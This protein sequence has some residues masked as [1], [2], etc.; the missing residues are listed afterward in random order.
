MAEAT[1]TEMNRFV[2][3]V[4]SFKNNLARLNSAETRNAVYASNNSALIRDYENTL[5][6]SN[7]LN[8]TIEGTVGAWE[9]A[10]SGWGIL[11]SQTSMW[12]GDAVDEIRSWFQTSN[13]LGCIGCPQLGSFGAVQ[14]PA[15]VWIAGIVAAAYALNKGMEK[16][17]IAIEATKMQE[18]NPNLSRERAVTLARNAIVG[19]WF[20]LA[21][22]VLLAAGAVGLYLV[23]RKR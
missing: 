8:S 13:N 16:I 12:I 6:Q 14:L 23:F 19:S 22:G 2:A 17:F 20:G 1:Q 5:T 11:T 4:E 15:A 10:K 18:A 21:P 9:A 3:I 7:I